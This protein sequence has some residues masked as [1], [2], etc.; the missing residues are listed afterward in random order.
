MDYIIN[1]TDKNRELSVFVA[2]TTDMVNTMRSIHNPSPVVCAAI[3]RSM[4][5]T[6]I[7][8]IGMKGE[9][10]KITTIIKGDGFIGNITCVSNNSGNVKACATNYNVDL[11]LR[12]DKK[13]NVGG[14][15]GVNGSLTII[16]DLGLKEPYIG[17]SQLVSGE[18]AEDYTNYLLTSE[19][20]RSAVGLGVLVDVD[21]TV[22]HAGGFIVCV[23]PFADEDTIL[24]VEKNI[25]NLSSVT[26]M[27]KDG[28]SPEDIADVLLSGL[29]CDILSKKGLTKC[30]PERSPCEYFPSLSTTYTFDSGTI[31]IAF[32]VI[33]NIIAN[34]TTII[35]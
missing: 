14:A 33:T 12:D 29:G 28:K 27:M 9:K 13:L 24:K 17:N 3:G 4:T 7:M 8:A 10:D 20:I 11:P 23:M 26:D 2:K 22:K 25:S 5:A 34:K 32:T 35:P 18:I 16:K 30:N 1:A 6:S 15:V 21:Y 31:F 19:Q